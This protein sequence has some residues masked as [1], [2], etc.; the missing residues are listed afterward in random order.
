[1]TDPENPNGNTHDVPLDNLQ[2]LLLQAYTRLFLLPERADRAKRTMVAG[3]GAYD[4]HLS[5]V[6]PAIRASTPRVFFVE[7]CETTSGRVIDSMGCYDL[8]DA[9]AAVDAFVAEAMS[10]SGIVPP[11]RT[12]FE[13]TQ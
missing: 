10:L 6:S 12:P 1:M 7:L 8:R 13:K 9:G 5:I 3:F 2:H 4:V 11:S